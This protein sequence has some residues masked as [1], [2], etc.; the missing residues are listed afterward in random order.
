MKYA[1][2]DQLDQ[3]LN[4]SL[5]IDGAT[6]KIVDRLGFLHDLLDDLVYA[7]VFNPDPRIKGRARWVIKTA[8]PGMGASVTSVTIPEI[9]LLPL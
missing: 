8:A 4:R 5:R 1:S 3:A 2:M 6:V 7:A 9:T